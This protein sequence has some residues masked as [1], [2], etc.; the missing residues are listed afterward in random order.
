MLKLGQYFRNHEAKIE[1]L[2][3]M[4]TIITL[5]SALTILALAMLPAKAQVTYFGTGNSLGNGTQNDGAGISSVV[6]NNNL[7]TIS[8]TINSTTTV[9]MASYIFYAIELQK[10]GGPV[11]YTGFS[12]PFGPAVGISTGVTGLLDTYGT[13]ATPYMAVAGN[14]VQQGSG[15]SYAGGGTGF[16]FATITVPLNSLG[17]SLGDSFYFDVVS[18][19]TSIQNGGGQSAY[20]ALDSVTGYPAES[21][22]MYTPYNGVSHYDSATDASGS[23]FGTAATLYTVGPVPEPATLSLL[24]LGALVMIR[25]AVRGKL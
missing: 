4:K 22:G 5:I 6:V 11:G 21:D 25:R 24:G 14:L 15:I 1:K 18:T 3:P 10:V 19:Y 20:G 17:L 23:T 7:S 13:G 2:T 8:F 9:G 12:N 16:N